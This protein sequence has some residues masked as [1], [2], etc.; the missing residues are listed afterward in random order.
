MQYIEFARRQKANKKLS[1]ILT[2]L[3]RLHPTKSAL[4]IYAAKYALE[5]K[6]DMTEARS[7]M[8]RA[9]RFCKHSRDLWLEYAKMEMMYISEIAA[10]G[11][12]LGRQEA[13]NLEADTGSEVLKLPAIIAPETDPNAAFDETVDEGVLAEL[14]QI[15]ALSGV[16]PMAIFDAAMKQFNNETIL[17]QQFFDVIASFR[18]VPCVAKVLQHVVDGLIAARPNSP[19]TLACYIQ[20]PTLVIGTKS[21]DFPAAIRTSLGRLRSSMEIL[22]TTQSVI[23]SSQARSALAHRVIEWLLWV[24]ETDDMD[25]D[26]AL[27]LYVTLKK[28]W[29]R[30]LTDLADNPGV[31]ADELSSLLKQLQAQGLPELAES[32]ITIG[33]RLWPKDKRFLDKVG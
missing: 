32:A 6:S 3:L 12:I 23:S 13:R 30:Y 14:Y 25:S 19:H 1:Q 10:R 9:L 33:S 26:I 17:G 16:I 5:E 11:R 4:W 31:S 28:T 27:V 15:P 7:Y 29:A 22:S 2:S 24:L 18:Y 21:A 20:Q 8:Q